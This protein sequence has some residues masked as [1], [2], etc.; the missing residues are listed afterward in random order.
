MIY[1]PEDSA[2]E[3]SLVRQGYYKCLIR[4]LNILYAYDCSDLLLLKRISK[5][6]EKTVDTAVLAD[7]IIIVKKISLLTGF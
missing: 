7:S 4:S 1:I 6:I 3:V 2:T 5:V